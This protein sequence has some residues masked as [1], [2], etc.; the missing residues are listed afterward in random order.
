M[1]VNCYKNEEKVDEI[2]INHRTKSKLCISF[3]YGVVSARYP[4]FV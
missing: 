3:N 4:L 1:F 2:E